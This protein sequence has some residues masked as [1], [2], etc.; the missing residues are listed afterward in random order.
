MYTLIIILVLI[1]YL[2][3]FFQECIN[4]WA[5]MDIDPELKVRY[6]KATLIRKI[7]LILL[8]FFTWPL[9]F[10]AARK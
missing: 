7:S 9:V 2:I 8:L 1:L 10:I 6:K 3:G 4:F 5:A